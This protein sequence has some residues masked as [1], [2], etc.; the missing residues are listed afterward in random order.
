M[1]EHIQVK[2]QLLKNRGTRV[3]VR[4][5]SIYPALKHKLEQDEF[6]YTPCLGAARSGRDV[7]SREYEAQA[8]MKSRALTRWYRLRGLEWM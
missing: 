8:V 3:Y 4:G 1:T 6:I 7:L 5:G 2:H